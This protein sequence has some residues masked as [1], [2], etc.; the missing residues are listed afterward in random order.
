MERKFVLDSNYRSKVCSII[1][2][3][4]EVACQLST[5]WEKKGAPI[6]IVGDAKFKA[7]M[8]GHNPCPPQAI[9][10]SLGRNFLTCVI[11]EYNTSKLCDKCHSYMVMKK[12]PNGYDGNPIK[13]GRKASASMLSVSENQRWIKVKARFK[14]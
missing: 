12:R 13:T 5:K 11:N 2:T 1:N 9:I 4:F 7:T 6:I 8:K 10:K 14:S 3:I